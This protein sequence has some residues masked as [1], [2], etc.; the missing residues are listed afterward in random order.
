MPRE[1]LVSY[2]DRT[3]TVT[4]VA[5]DDHCSN[6]CLFMASNATRCTL[7][8]ELTW[9]K[10]KK[11]NGNKRPAACRGSEWEDTDGSEERP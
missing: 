5:S 8:G 9:D 3:I 10:R 1:A 4:V 7:F 11:K 2:Q 6:D